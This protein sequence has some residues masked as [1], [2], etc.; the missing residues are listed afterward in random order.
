MRTA[1]SSFRIEDKREV[2]QQNILRRRPLNQR[3]QMAPGDPMLQ[4]WMQ[5]RS[6]RN[7]PLCKRVYL[8]RSLRP[9]NT[10]LQI[11]L[12]ILI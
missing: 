5:K 8:N 3:K 2:L 11:T 1:E 9:K 7:T 4:A 6:P 10:N 12:I